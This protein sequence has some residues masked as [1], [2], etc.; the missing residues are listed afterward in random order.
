VPPTN[1]LPSGVI[2]INAAWAGHKEALDVLE[3]MV[4]V[5]MMRGAQSGGVVTYASGGGGGG[6]RGGNPQLRGIRSR[7]VNGKR[8]DLSELVRQKV[9]RNDGAWRPTGFT[10]AYSGHTR[11]ATT[12]KA[13]FDGTHP[14]Q[15]CPPRPRRVY[16][17]HD[18]RGA[19]GHA[20]S[21]QRQVEHFITH[22]GDLDF[23]RVSG[24][25]HELSKVQ[26]W[27]ERVLEQPMPATVDSACIAGLVDLHR[28]AGC[29][30]LSVRYA[31]Q[32]GLRA[33]RG[34]DEEDDPPTYQHYEKCGAVFEVGG[35]V[36]V[37]ECC[38][39]C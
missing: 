1:P 36:Q 30:G 37:V 23:F 14:H 28:A 7:V 22:N 16:F 6:G 24:V 26:R 35:A 20:G 4:F 5:T 11:F 31:H 27:L 33:S 32:C 17:M 3:K 15:W 2:L 39:S 13:S 10:R 19:A 18:T 12:S 29:W 8:T 21:A 9:E 34:P 38:C 25:W